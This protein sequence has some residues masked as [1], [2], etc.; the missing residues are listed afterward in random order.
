[1]SDQEFSAQELHQ[2]DQIFKAL[3]QLRD[4]TGHEKRG[5]Q[6]GIFAT[7]QGMILTSLPARTRHKMFPRDVSRSG[8]GFLSRRPFK[9]SER[10]VITLPHPS[11]IERVLL[12][13]TVFCRYTSKSMHE[14][15][16]MFEATITAPR[17][18]GKIP[19]EWVEKSI[20]EL[21]PRKPAAA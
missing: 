15:G 9:P 21:A 3:D 20:S 6:R 12:C 8:I 18:K 19:I 2:V 10:F 13:K 7:A 16:A 11:G 17:G 5:A 14:I 4:A 1:M